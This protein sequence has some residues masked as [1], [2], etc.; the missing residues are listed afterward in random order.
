MR[1]LKKTLSLVLVV[2]MVLGLC[3]VGASAY[4]KVEDFTDDVDKIGDAYYEAVGVL[5]GIGVI[6]GMTETA[7]E[8][9][10]NYTRE[11]AAK[12][13]AYMMLGKDKADSLK[14]TVA[15]FDDVAATRWSAGYIAYCVE[16]GI[17]DG[18]TETTFEPTGKLTGFQWAKMLLCAVGFG[19]NDEFTGSSWSVNTAKVAHTVNLFAGDLAGA[20]H[21]ALT[22]EQAALYAFNVLTNVKKVA[23]SANVTSYVY[24]IRGYWTVDGIGSTLGE[25]VYKLS[26]VEGI[27]VDN[28][29]I[30]ASCTVL[31]KDYTTA[32]AF[33]KIKAN[34]DIDE[35][36]H[37]VRVWYVGTNTG[38]FT[39]DLAEAT[40][41][42]CMNMNA[43]A[44]AAAAIKVGYATPTIGSGYAYE[45]VLVDNSAYAANSYAYVTV[46]AALG[47]MGYAG[48]K[49]TDIDK[50]AVANANIKT[51]ISKISYGS[52]ILYIAA[53]STTEKGEAWY[54]YPVTSTSGV[55]KSFTK[56]GGVVISVTLEDGT[57]LPV[58]A[59]AKEYQTS[60]TVE[61]YVIGNVYLFVLDTHGDIIYATRDTVRDLWVYTG[62]GM[63]TNEFTAISSD[64]AWS[65]RFINVS[66]GEIKFFPISGWT[67]L[68]TAKAG[69]YY[70]ISASTTTKG[71]YV[72]A[73]V[74]AAKNPYAAEY[75]IDDF[76]VFKTG[77]TSAYAD[78]SYTGKK[79]YFNPN[80]IVFLVA[81]GS[82][83]NMTVKSYTG[84]DALKQDYSVASNGS[85]ELKDAVFTVTKTV[86]GNPYATTVFVL[87][88][89]LSTTSNY[90]FIPADITNTS[91]Q[92]VTGD[93]THYTV[94][95]KGAY[96]EGTEITV[97]FDAEEL[98]N[99]GVVLD[100]GFYTYT[101]NRNG[102]GKYELVEKVD[103]G[104]N[105]LCYY[106]NVQFTAT[107]LTDNWLF[108]GRHTAV[109]GEAKIIDLTGEGI[110]TLSKL[111]Q[112]CTYVNSTVRLAYTVNPN[113]THVDYVYVT[114]SGWDAQVN[115]SLTSELAAAGWTISSVN[116]E[117]QPAD[118]TS[119]AYKDAAAEALVGT[120]VDVVLYN[121]NLAGV[122][123][124][125]AYKATINGADAYSNLTKGY[126]G[127]KINVNSMVSGTKTQ[128]FVIG[129]LSLGDVEVTLSNPDHVFYG[130]NGSST[131]TFENVVLGTK[132][133]FVFCQKTGNFD[134]DP[135]TEYWSGTYNGKTIT[136]DLF[137]NT[138][139]V[140]CVKTSIIPL[141]DACTVSPSAWLGIP[142][143]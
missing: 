58:S 127:L 90:V 47:Q 84:I 69:L 138:N 134:A 41:Y 68:E 67:G 100:R 137:E 129:G 98:G 120:G 102:N 56:E 75:V 23:Y 66:T 104:Y 51:D 87:A 124:T 79:V 111:Y 135:D 39:T 118:T 115:I 46:K 139:G 131:K 103:N 64:W 40:V 50:N 95:Y 93:P 31:S 20:D 53:E 122:D 121:A 86:T 3:V 112:Y 15:P 108:N 96:L 14:C 81:V 24:G 123:G 42:E 30:G 92:T 13:I 117:A 36:Y 85:V 106:S 34:T 99:D 35:M 141:S 74:T 126:I 65:Y 125:S 49:S 48:S 29:G 12:I 52:A 22:R 83:A 110:T 133:E 27:I 114:N 142:N 18:M 19:V 59:L 136:G 9:Q 17:I 26:N 38:V 45:T 94:S 143:P 60:D 43:G 80:E 2:A 54:V 107:N 25:D 32:K 72:A 7:F 97:Y 1:T 11:Q 28:E 6:D 132:V 61:Q 55:V 71:E 88:S 76:A 73:N 62:E 77:S 82:G 33:A 37:A 16:Q 8:P 4:N 140:Y 101:F 113:T 78:G 116:G 89:K 91:W 57:V 109:E 5:T 130:T 21:T 63:W 10:G 119:I 105:E 44:K 128:N 70:D